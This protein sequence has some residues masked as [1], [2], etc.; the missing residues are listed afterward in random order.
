MVGY[1][2]LADSAVLE[3]EGLPSWIRSVFVVREGEIL[4]PEQAGRLKAGDYGYFLAPPKR[5]PRLDR[6]FAPAD[7]SAGPASSGVFTFHGSVPMETL[8]GL[9][10]LPVPDDLQSLTIAE[11]FADRFEERIEPGD[12]IRLGSAVLIA[13]HVDDEVVADAALEI[14]E[15]DAPDDS[16]RILIGPVA[17]LFKAPRRDLRSGGRQPPAA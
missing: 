7:G 12:R 13:T 1:P 14:D 10:G 16:R 9:Y 17:R 2:I 6:L 3:R 4:S 11:A 15:F 5:V 8:S